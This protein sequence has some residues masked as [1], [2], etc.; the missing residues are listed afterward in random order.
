MTMEMLRKM[1]IRFKTTRTVIWIRHEQN[2]VRELKWSVQGTELC[3]DYDDPHQNCSEA[4]FPLTRHKE[5][6]KQLEQVRFV[7]AF[8]RVKSCAEI[9]D[10]ALRERSAE[11][12]EI[13]NNISDGIG[14]V[15]SEDPK[16]S[17]GADHGP[18]RS[19]EGAVEALRPEESDDD[20]RPKNVEDGHF[21][22]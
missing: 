6:P 14:R 15:V 10:D 18:D 8:R 13:D 1:K 20:N 16:F 2:D 22:G 5:G 7:H 19:V 11:H 4:I 21:E 9:H 12:D 17:D 3:K